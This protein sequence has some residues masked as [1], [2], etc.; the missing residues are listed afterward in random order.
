MY[1]NAYR[2][3]NAA[4]TLSIGDLE[5]FSSS[6]AL[7]DYQYNTLTKNADIMVFPSYGE[8]F[9]TEDECINSIVI[10]SN[11]AEYIVSRCEKYND[12]SELIGEDI[13]IKNIGIKNN[14]NS[15]SAKL[16]IFSI[17]YF[18]NN[19]SNLEYLNMFI[20]QSHGNAIY[21]SNLVF[22]SLAFNENCDF[23]S[24]IIYDGKHNYPFR[25]FY[26]LKE[27][28]G[29]T[30]AF[31][32]P[33]SESNRLLNY[34]FAQMCDVCEMVLLFKSNVARVVLNVVFSSLIVFG[35]CALFNAF[36]LIRTGKLHNNLWLLFYFVFTICCPIFL[37]FLM[38]LFLQSV[39]LNGI[40]VP[41]IGT[42]NTSC[43]IV[44][45]SIYMLLGYIRCRF[46]KTER[47]MQ[48]NIDY[49]IIEI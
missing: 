31:S 40:S 25:T 13:Y 43:F 1:S 20:Y 2:I 33:N 35:F 36:C 41:L 17:A 45:S 3:A 47:F 28:L 15:V 8:K 37:L 5:D 49:A 29:D 16:K 34:Y 14:K 27:L 21:I 12:I 26:Y 6:S 48:H 11:T 7:I 10:D 46:S 9:K 19:K 39:T 18:I 24:N 32:F 22:D 30:S 4:Y 44:L 42:G 23:Y 38:F